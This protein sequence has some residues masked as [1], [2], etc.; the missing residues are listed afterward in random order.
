[1]R[2]YLRQEPHRQVTAGVGS[3][4][5]GAPPAT[6]G[7]TLLMPLHCHGKLLRRGDAWEGSAV[8]GEL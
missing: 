4:G 5:K 7:V 8:I 2:E 1:M 3:G 6:G